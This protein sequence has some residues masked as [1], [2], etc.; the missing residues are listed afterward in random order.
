MLK[1]IISVALALSIFTGCGSSGGD[2]AP[3]VVP[4]ALSDINVT[5]AEDNTLSASL[6][7]MYSGTATL[8]Y[9]L[10]SSAT[11]GSVTVLAS[12]SFEYIP[13]ANFNGTDSFSVIANNGIN[14]EPAAVTVIVSSVN[15]T[16]YSAD[17]N[18]SLNENDSISA[19]LSG[20]DVEGGPL[21]YTLVANSLHGST[22]VDTNGSFTYTP[23][24]AY[25]GP[26]S[27]SYKIN[28]G[29]LDSAAVL[30]NMTVNEINDLPVASNQT[31]TTNENIAIVSTFDITDTN[32]G[33]T[34]TC[35]S[36]TAPL[37][38]T[39]DIG[40]G[41]N[42][43]YT[44]YINYNGDDSF[45]VKCNDGTVDSAVATTSIT[46]FGV[47]DEPILFDQTKTLNEDTTLSAFLAGDDP[48]GDPITCYM[49][50]APLHG[51]AS[52]TTGKNY[53]YTPVLNY[54]GTDSFTSYCKDD[55]NLSSTIVTST[56]SISPVNDVPT[57]N[58]LINMLIDKGLTTA[59]SA[60]VFTDVDTSDTLSYS[61]IT[62]GTNGNFD[63]SG[64]DV[65]YTN[66]STFA[67]YDSGVIQVSDGNGGLVNVAVNIT[68]NII[69]KIISHPSEKS[70]LALKEDGTVY[71]W[72][73]AENSI[74]ESGSSTV[75]QVYIGEGTW[76]DMSMGLE[77]IC[78][79]KKTDKTLWCAGSDVYGQSGGSSG[80]TIPSF[81]QVG[82]DTDWKNI[83]TTQYSTSILKED[84]TI[85]SIGRNDVN[86]SGL[87]NAG[88]DITSLT[89]M[90][91]DTNWKDLSCDPTDN[92]CLATKTDNTLWSWG[93][94]ATKQLG[95][96]TAQAVPVQVGT[97][98]D[99]DKI[100]SVNESSFAIKTNGTLHS[101]G[102]SLYDGI[103]RGDDNLTSEVVTQIGTDTDWKSVSYSSNAA[104]L[105][106]NNGEIYG[107]GN[108]VYGNTLNII[109]AG[110]NVI[111]EIASLDTNKGPVKITGS[112]DDWLSVQLNLKSA[113]GINK[114]GELN[115]WGDNSYGELGNGIAL[116]QDHLGVSNFVAA[117]WSLLTDDL[118]IKSDGTL[119]SWGYNR[120]GNLGNG[121]IK[122]GSSTP[123]LT[124][125]NT[126]WINT[127]HSESLAYGL[128]SDGTL[129]SWG[130][131]GYGGLINEIFAFTTAG[132]RTSPGQ[133]G[134][135]TDWTQIS[136]NGFGIVARKSN[137]TI[138][139]GGNNSFGQLGLGDKN[140]VFVMTQIGTDSDWVDIS[141]NEKSLSAV[142]A[143]GTLW[144]AGSNADNEL[145]LGSGVTEALTLTQVG[146][147]TD[148]LK[149]YGCVG[150][151]YK[152][153]LKTNDTIYSWGATSSDQGGG[154]SGI[155][156]TPV[157]STLTFTPTAN[158]V[159]QPEGSYVLGTDQKVYSS[160]KV[161]GDYSDSNT[162]VYTQF[163]TTNYSGL[164][165][166]KIFPTYKGIKILTTTGDVLTGGTEYTTNNLQTTPLNVAY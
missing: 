150:C 115:T 49:V 20:F 62:N 149:T 29:V 145:G 113:A 73:Q 124:D 39:L 93:N 77:H 134:T 59:S 87:D 51:T 40:L 95:Y 156:E 119:W 130:F 14:S 152:I 106:K 76:L 35:S 155:N 28:D 72:G 128:R 81:V 75:S 141:L 164:L 140:N 126:S 151:N 78:G 162:T 37:H 31:I 47:N 127:I 110:E 161:Y 44:P 132:I 143:N 103:C 146:V 125:N 43:T 157:Q 147:D 53:T 135:D 58:T 117:D 63:I 18:F 4:V 57:G 24:T 153:G 19:T 85:W 120:H 27:F 61:V 55:S 6:S 166:T 69:R 84:G 23:V 46:I 15:D 97:A 41:V 98:A 108:L 121:L 12:G 17:G 131:N 34:L 16:P 79:I 159:A 1:H 32:I 107:C 96:L 114:Y 45:S 8:S 158:I 122:I 99:W 116:G 94:N 129:W 64:S 83:E 26:D 139:S 142:K 137:G 154:D 144:V 11:N 7:S 92:H 101:W 60:I 80:A 163:S 105:L 67:D 65:V 9:S 89:Q 118:G 3:Q 42:Y 86:Q 123:A 13:N 22:V 91:T 111:D 70:Y 104:L 160:G 48:E 82:T 10:S 5:V 165:A 25:F 138:W 68:Y 21:T 30:V 71:M 52:F 54:N 88:A 74:P 36:V 148:W 136:S 50:S 56:M 38:G 102:N 33:D 112:N 109:L 66:T 100:F 90:G 2:S 133:V